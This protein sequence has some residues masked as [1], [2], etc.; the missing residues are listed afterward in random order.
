MKL[1]H[2]DKQIL[3]ILQEQGRIT[4]SDLADKINLTPPPTAERVKKLEKNGLIRKYVALMDPTK[5]DFN[6]FIFVEIVLSKHGQDAVNEF[7]NA[8]VEL[9]E[10]MECHH[11]T[12]KADFLLKVIAKD[13]P[14]YRE[15]MISV[16]TALPHVK[17]LETFVVLSTLK[18]ETKFPIDE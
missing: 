8:I 15:F 7:M 18:Q 9:D 17:H 6:S 14:T 4:N 11:I 13:I 12:G 16:L 1:D 5:I 3:R 10:V 2:I